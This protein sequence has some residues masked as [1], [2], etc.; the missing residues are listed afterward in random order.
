MVN[1]TGKGTDAEGHITSVSISVS[2]SSPAPTGFPDASN[3]GV[4]VGTILQRIPEDITSGAGWHWD[5]RGWVTI[6]D[7]GAVFDKY[8]VNSEVDATA[9]GITISRC[10]IINNG[11]VFGVGLRHSN[12]VTV[13]DCTISGPGNGGPDNN[14]LTTGIKDVY[15]DISGTVIKRCNIFDCAG[16][17]AL[18]KG[19]VQ[20]NYIHDMGYNTV[21]HVD[22]YQSFDVGPLEI[23]GNKFLN[24]LNQTAC[25]LLQWTNAALSGV[26]IHDNL[27]AGGGYCIYGGDNAIDVKITNNKF[28]TRFYPN[29]GYYGYVAHW[30]PGNTGDEWSGNTWYDGP[31]V[32]QVIN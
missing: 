24:E 19:I 30:Q 23:S 5:T 4:P 10:R 9:D 22:C 6:D 27:F 7:A 18:H 29:G 1:I 12:N 15:G 26:R 20:N 16:G 11:N 21:D 17:I 28:S 31:N 25:I 8:S 3:T 2:V 13:Q 14:R 32:G